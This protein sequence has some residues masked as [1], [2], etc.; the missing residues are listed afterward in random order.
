MNSDQAQLSTRPLSSFL[1]NLKAGLRALFFLRIS[2]QENNTGWSQLVF[3]TLF[4]LAIRFA[5]DF[6]H[7]GLNGEL[8]LF[9]LPGALFGLPLMLLTAWALAVLAKQPE[10]TLSLLIV[11]SAMNVS[12]EVCSLA[13]Q[14]AFDQKL[15]RA[16]VPRS[17]HLTD[18]VMIAWLVL[19]CGLAAIRFLNIPVR[20]RI[21]ALLVAILFIGVPLSKIYHDKTLWMP[22]YGQ[23]DRSEWRRND[24]L[25]N[26]D[27]FYLQPQLLERELAAVTPSHMEGIDLYFVGVAGYSS[28]DVFMK[29]VE[30]VSGQVKK[31]YGASGHS[32]LLINNPKTAKERPIASTTSL[33]LS[34]KKIGAMMDKNKDILFL[35]LTS[36]GSSDHKFSLNFG[37]MQFNELDP[38]RLRKI[39]DESGIKRRVIVVSAC[40]SGGFVDALKNEDTLVITSSAPDKTSFGCSNEADFTYFGKAY[41][42]DALEK[43]DS[44]IEA[45]ELAKPL[46]AARENEDDYTPSDPR[47]FVGEKIKASLAEL[48]QQLSSNRIEKNLASYHQALPSAEQ[49]ER[50][51]PAPA[52]SAAV[53]DGR[54][55]DAKLQAARSLVA[56]LKFDAMVRESMKQCKE[57]AKS[58]SPESIVKATPNYFRGITP[59]SPLW[60]KVVDAYK[61]YFDASC[62]YMNDDY[63]AAMAQAYASSMTLDELSKVINFYSTPAGKK[64]AVAN[65]A[66]SAVLQKEMSAR[67]SVVSEKANA[68]FIEKIAELAAME[69]RSKGAGPSATKSWWR[70][71]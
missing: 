35:Y 55:E 54:T 5:W 28:Q 60:P 45:F 42:E 57:T 50:H 26:E 16:F 48:S 7:V 65:Q 32:I 23:D 9:G 63:A 8:S 2:P 11:F 18:K 46:I 15:I 30:Y 3:I 51:E 69:N 68:R 22:S 52:P 14:W 25:A 4:N 37:S 39:L 27:I 12:Y 44:F 47:I 31:R 33:S 53:N 62:N 40:Y 36:H 67:M 13:L 70:F 34:M 71:W 43:T 66:S 58:R 49:E 38:Q 41:F 19:A 64:L 20:T 1:V 24:A 6:V 61:D 56:L 10:K 59:Q 17:W 21:P 29:E